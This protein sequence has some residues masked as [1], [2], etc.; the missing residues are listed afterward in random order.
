MWRGA[1]ALPFG[2]PRGPCGREAAESILDRAS[3]ELLFA[4]EIGELC[5]EDA[6]EARESGLC[7]VSSALSLANLSLSTSAPFTPDAAPNIGRPCK[8]SGFGLGVGL[9]LRGSDTPP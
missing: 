8:L 2:I 3:K 1:G 9:T 5:T 6:F 7:C 4:I